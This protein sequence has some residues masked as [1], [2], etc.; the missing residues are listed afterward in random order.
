MRP[1]ALV[2]AVIALF[3]EYNTSLS[4]EKLAR[5]KVL[6]EQPESP[7]RTHNSRLSPRKR[8]THCK[9]CG[10]T[11]LVFHSRQSFCESCR[12]ANPVWQKS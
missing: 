2:P 5:L 4:P 9:H 8:I 12:S 7:T 11:N 3:A 1:K 6:T 10:S